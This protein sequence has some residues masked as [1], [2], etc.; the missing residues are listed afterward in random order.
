M[1]RKIAAVKKEAAKARAG[2]NSFPQ[3]PFLFARPSVQFWFCRPQGGNHSGFCSKLV[4][5]FYNKHHE[6]KTKN[7]FEVMGA[8]K[9]F[10]I[11]EAQKLVRDFAAR[12]KWK[13]APNVD[14]FDHLHEELIEMS[15]HLRYKSEKE[16]KDY[17]KKNKE[18]FKDG[19]GDL[20]F[21]LCRLAN[22]LEVDMEGAFNMVKDEILAKYNHKSAENNIVREK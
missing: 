12:N 20:F 10:T 8:K 7:Y 19:I 17:V 21:G 1:A 11:K 2:K 13:D 3:T 16:R 5:T 4:L 9:V 6:Y 15:Q 14:K 22:Q 18:V